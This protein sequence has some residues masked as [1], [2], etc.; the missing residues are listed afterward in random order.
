MKV[1]PHN[2]PLPVVSEYETETYLTGGQCSGSL[3][4]AVTTEHQESVPYMIWPYSSVGR[5]IGC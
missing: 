1:R 4:V 3:V 2:L 5:A